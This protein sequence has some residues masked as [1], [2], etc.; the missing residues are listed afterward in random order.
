[1]QGL[2]PKQAD[3]LYR[4]LKQTPGVASVNIKAASLASWRAMY[5]AYIESEC[6]RSG[7]EATG[8]TPL[9][10]ELFRVVWREPLR[11]GAS[12]LA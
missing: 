1:M 4:E 8:Q 10:M 7:R 6:A 2:D 9:V 12:G 5:W 3:S 11:A